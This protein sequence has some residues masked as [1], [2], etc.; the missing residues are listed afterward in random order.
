MADREGRVR[1]MVMR[2]GMK[3]SSHDLPQM[4]SE[5]YRNTTLGPKVCRAMM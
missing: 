4:K 5:K 2:T 3:I 1:E